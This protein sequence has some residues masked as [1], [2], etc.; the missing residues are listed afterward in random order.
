MAPQLVEADPALERLAE[1]VEAGGGADDVLT[2]RRELGRRA[3]WWW[4]EVAPR[5][6]TEDGSL[7]SLT[8]A[9]QRRQALRYG[10]MKSEELLADDLEL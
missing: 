3:L 6:E 2:S 7:P 9:L 8:E 1:H 4:A 5:I 10:D